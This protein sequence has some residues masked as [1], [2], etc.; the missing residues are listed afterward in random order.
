MSS[1]EDVSIPVHKLKTLLLILFGLYFLDSFFLLKDDRM[2]RIIFGGFDKSQSMREEFLYMGLKE[3]K[4]IILEL[5]CN[6][7][8]IEGILIQIKI[9]RRINFFTYLSFVSF[10]VGDTTLFG[11]KKSR[12]L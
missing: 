7:T 12:S 10:S 8:I 2:F 5:K 4:M 9:L 6:H 1:S 11:A 3:I